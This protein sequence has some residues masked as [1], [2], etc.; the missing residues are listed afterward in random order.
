MENEET[1]DQQN[2]IDDRNSNEDQEKNSGI[3]KNVWDHDIFD[4]TDP[5]L[6][7]DKKDPKRTL[8]Y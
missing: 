4:D 8:F 6:R 3:N 1:A 5:N 7:K 2:T